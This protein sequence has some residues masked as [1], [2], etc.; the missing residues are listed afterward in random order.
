M[1]QSLVFFSRGIPTPDEFTRAMR[2]LYS[3]SDRAAALVGGAILEMILTEALKVF[4]HHNKRI[5]DDLFRPSG[6]C[7]AFATK[8]HL[9]FLTG[10]YGAVAHKDLTTVKDIR[11]AFAHSLAINDFNAQRIRSLT[12]KLTLCERY[13]DGT[14]KPPGE[15]QGW[16]SVDNRDAAL[17]MPRERYLITVQVLTYGLSVPNGT[18]MPA[19]QF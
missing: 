2:E 12:E 3:G 19:P 7:G 14:G 1:A 10:L 6:A 8:I 5:T 18:G 9:G 11:N 16:F 17:K 4:L 13:T 15:R